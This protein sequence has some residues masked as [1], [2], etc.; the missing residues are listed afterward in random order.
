MGIQGKLREYKMQ[1]PGITGLQLM[2][3]Q[4]LQVQMAN[5]QR[6]RSRPLT[7]DA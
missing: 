7:L 6:P 3:G 2:F 5:P 4:W 1:Q